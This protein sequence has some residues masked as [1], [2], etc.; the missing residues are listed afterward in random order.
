MVH[1]RVV[2]HCDCTRLTDVS[3]LCLSVVE[4]HLAHT[5]E[6]IF[7]TPRMWQ[8]NPAFTSPTPVNSRTTRRC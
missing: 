7:P 1:N 4:Q 8:C 5:L 2:H 3:M 6:S